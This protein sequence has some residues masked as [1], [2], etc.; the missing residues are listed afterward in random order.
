YLGGPP[1]HLESLWGY[2]FSHAYAKAFL[3]V[4]RH[5]VRELPGGLLQNIVSHGLAK[6][7]EFLASDSL[8]ILAHG[9]IS[10]MLQ[11]L[12][13]TEIV[14]ELRV[15]ICDGARTTAYFTFSSQMRPSVHQFRVYGPENGLVL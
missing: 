4:K 15:I 9:F 13:E 14:D 12:G 3:G 1:V 5:W 10:P 6:L 8:T 7:A 11:S 2:Q